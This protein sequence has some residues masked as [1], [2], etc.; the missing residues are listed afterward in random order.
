MKVIYLKFAQETFHGI[1]Y[2]QVTK[3]KTIQTSMSC[4]LTMITC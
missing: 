3:M 2:T 4:Q 1:R